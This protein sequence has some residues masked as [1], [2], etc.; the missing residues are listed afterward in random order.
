MYFQG[1]I[2]LTIQSHHPRLQ[3]SQTRTPTGHEAVILFSG[4]YAMAIGVGGVKAVLPAHGADQ[5]DPNNQRAISSFFNW[6][7]FSLCIGGV[8]TATVMVWVE[9]NLGWNWSF[10]ISLFSLCLALLMFMGGYRV[11]T[12]KIPGG[13]PL[14][15]IFK[16]T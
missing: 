9:E 2:I 7:F 11:Y 5:F 13:S 14:A 1:L 4:L 8:I 3:P 15:R 16:V 12:Y 6:F 10:T